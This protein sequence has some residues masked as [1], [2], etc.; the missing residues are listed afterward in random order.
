[1]CENLNEMIEYSNDEIENRIEILKNIFNDKCIRHE[2]NNEVNLIN[3]ISQGI[4]E[5][6]IDDNFGNYIS[7]I[8]N[9]SISE[10]DY[11]YIIFIK[12]SNNVVKL[13]RFYKLDSPQTILERLHTSDFLKNKILNFSL[14]EYIADNIFELDEEKILN[15]KKPLLNMIDVEDDFINVC[16]DR[17]PKFASYIKLFFNDKNTIINYFLSSFRYGTKYIRILNLAL[18]RNDINL[19]HDIDNKLKEKNCSLKEVIE[20]IESKELFL[21]IHEDIIIQIIKEF[22]I[23]FSNIESYYLTD[24][25]LKYV[26]ENNCYYI[27]KD[28]LIYVYNYTNDSNKN[29]EEILSYKVLSKVNIIS[30]YIK[31]SKEYFDKYFD[32][33]WLNK[34]NFIEDDE[35]FIEILHYVISDTSRYQK[36]INNVK[37]RFM[38][39]AI[40]KNTQVIND[41][42]NLNK[43][44]INKDNLIILCNNY[45]GKSLIDFINANVKAI[46]KVDLNNVAYVNIN[47]YIYNCIYDENDRLTF[48]YKNANSYNAQ[49]VISKLETIEFD[50]M[51][52]FDTKEEILI[53]EKSKIF[54]E[55][56][57]RIKF[58]KIY[59]DKRRTSFTFRWRLC[60]T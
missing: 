16:F 40:I 37:I 23:K 48:L 17:I 39:I 46:E 24:R 11:N 1:M 26:I 7:Y 60:T 2:Y 43:I 8:Y 55:I 3:F 36:F 41:L 14:L 34:I 12:D 33:V 9:I 32:D 31:S 50:L 25:V 44:E 15:I 35:S 52:E 58:I 18:N 54:A 56:L 59:K 19:L 22:Q 10:N 6:Y 45:R 27:N 20:S 57:E 30:K 42:I 53:N 13:D 29:E 38:S 21:N 49:N 28:N 47:D 51:K 5:G 4:F